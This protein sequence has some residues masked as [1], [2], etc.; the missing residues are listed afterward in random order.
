M[1]N[2]CMTAE[3]KAERAARIWVVLGQLNRM[4]AEDAELSLVEYPAWKLRRILAHLLEVRGIITES[5]HD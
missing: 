2:D 1:A 4:M 3:E 5:D